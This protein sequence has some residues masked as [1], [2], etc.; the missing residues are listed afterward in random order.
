M[1]GY[2][3]DGWEDPPLP[4]PLGFELGIARQPSGHSRSGRDSHQPGVACRTPGPDPHPP[5]VLHPPNRDGYDDHIVD[6]RSGFM[7]GAHSPRCE[8]TGL[9]TEALLRATS[10]RPAGEQPDA[11]R[12][13][14]VLAQPVIPPVHPSRAI[15][16][17]AGC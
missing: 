11:G 1:H 17:Y 6:A 2:S 10:S 5:L 14:V 7:P 8:V 4:G 16:T 13:R 12:D 3:T 15:S 9:M